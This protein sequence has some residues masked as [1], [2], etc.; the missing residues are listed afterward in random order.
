MTSFIQFYH[1]FS[2]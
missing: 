2:H 1:F